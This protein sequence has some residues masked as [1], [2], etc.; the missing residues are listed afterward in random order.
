MRCKGVFES[1][2]TDFDTNGV[3]HWLGT[4]GGTTAYANPHTTGKVIVNSSSVFEGGAVEWFIGH[5]PPPSSD[6][7]RGVTNSCVDATGSFVTV[8]LPADIVLNRYT[9]RHG[10][11]YKYHVLRNWNLSGSANGV[12]W[13]VLHQHVN[14]V[15]LAAAPSSTA[16]W[17]VNPDGLAFSHFRIIMTGP[18][19]NGNQ[20]LSMGGLELYGRVGLTPGTVSA[21]QPGCERCSSSI[22]VS[23][24]RTHILLL[25]PLG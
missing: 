9:L 4:N 18:N 13:V 10:M 16:S 2:G 23:I 12:D 6:T 11:N 22:I 8:Q 20:M 24:C 19:F 17:D 21:A 25:P 14:D 7:S 5:A 3:L 15:S 1:A